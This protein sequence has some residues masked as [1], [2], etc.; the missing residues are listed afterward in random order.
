MKELA[1]TQESAVRLLNEYDNE[2]DK[3]QAFSK[4]LQTCKDEIAHYIE[5]TD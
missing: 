4:E 2:K 5:H 1:Q 3:S